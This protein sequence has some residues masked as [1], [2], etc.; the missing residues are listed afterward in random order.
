MKE[1]KDRI[2]K[3]VSSLIGDLMV[4]LDSIASN[5]NNDDSFSAPPAVSDGAPVWGAGGG[6]VQYRTTEMASQHPGTSGVMLQGIVPPHP[7]VPDVNVSVPS[8]RNLELGDKED[9]S[10]IPC[11]QGHQLRNLD[12]STSS[13]AFNLDHL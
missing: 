5:R 7:L 13:L 9:S 3:N 12:A 4:K 11:G 8:N 2:N 6:R 10:P 1:L